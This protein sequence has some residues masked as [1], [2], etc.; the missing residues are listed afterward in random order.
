MRGARRESDLGAVAPQMAFAR[1]CGGSQRAAA[2]EKGTERSKTVSNLRPSK[3]D[4]A[5]TSCLFLLGTCRRAFG[6]E[7][8]LSTSARES[9]SHPRVSSRLG[10]CTQLL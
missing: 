5:T 10:R 8:K 9:L 6:G 1:Y 3:D 7:S 2:R 4:E